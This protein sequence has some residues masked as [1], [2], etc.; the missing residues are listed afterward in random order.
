MTPQIMLHRWTASAQALLRIVVALLFLQHG[1]AKLVDFPHMEN[2]KQVFSVFGQMSDVFRV[3]AGLIETIGGVL[4]AAGFVTRGVAFV[5]CGFSAV[6]YF[7][8]HAPQSF[9]PALNGGEHSVLFCFTT[10]F[11]AAGGPGSW[12]I[13]KS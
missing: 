3:T 12:A 4:L 2:I 8:V 1:L 9:F 7:I 6:A 10:L 5:L 11:L 13:D